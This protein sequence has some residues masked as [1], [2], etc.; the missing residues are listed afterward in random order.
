MHEFGYEDSGMGSPGSDFH[1]DADILADGK[2]DVII[3]E[4][5]P[6]GEH[7]EKS[8]SS[9]LDEGEWEVDTIYTKFSGLKNTN[10]HE[11]LEIPENAEYGHYHFH[12]MV[13]DMEGNQ[14]SMERE[15]EIT[16]GMDSHAH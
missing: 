8:R 4:I 14:T 15:L 11:H 10:F 7:E 1:I 12:L 5:H 9:I 6:E 16:D 3:V 13:N 2:I